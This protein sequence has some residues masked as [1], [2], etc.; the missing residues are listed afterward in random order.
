MSEHEHEY[1]FPIEL[2]KSTSKQH[3]INK[4]IIILQ[5]EFNKLKYQLDELEIKIAIL[6]DY[7]ALIE[8]QNKNNT[9]AV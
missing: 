9:T 8:N 6:V 4:Q 7:N 2:L 1:S 3:N 5:T